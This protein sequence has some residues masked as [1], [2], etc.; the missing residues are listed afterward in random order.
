MGR[1][2]PQILIDLW[3]SG[4]SYAKWLFKGL[5]YGSSTSLTSCL[6][7]LFRYMLNLFFFYIFLFCLS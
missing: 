1:D 3:G 2:D 5:D 6:P 4:I 7:L